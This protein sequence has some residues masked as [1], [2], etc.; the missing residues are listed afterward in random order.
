MSF[1]IRQTTKEDCYAI[2]KLINELAV[3]EKMPEGP[4]INAATL[5]K[6]GGFEDENEHKFYHSYVAELDNEVIG[7]VLFYY[8]YST[9]EGKSIWMEDLYCQPNHRGKGVGT[10]LWRE[11]ARR[12]ERENCCRLDFAVLNWNEPSIAFY[13]HNG[14]CNI[15][16]EQGWNVFRLSKDGIRALAAK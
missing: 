13:K 8:I 6:D 1:I 10:A 16:E 15:S 2:E 3:Y 7:F 5:I 14:A 4:K 12:A 9:W 11:V